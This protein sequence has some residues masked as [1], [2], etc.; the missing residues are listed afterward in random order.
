MQSTKWVLQ[1]RLDSGGR[2]VMD[3]QTITQAI[4]KAEANGFLIDGEKPST[5]TWWEENHV[6]EDYSLYDIIFSHEFAKA[7]WSGCSDINYYRYGEQSD[8]AWKSHLLQM[9]LS[10]DPIE[11][12]KLY[13]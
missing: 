4:L 6:V 5:L 11:Y 2:K 1:L 8:I 7:F 3:K 10:E 9:V 12:L 13:L